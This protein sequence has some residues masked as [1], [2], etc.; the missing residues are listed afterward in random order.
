MSGVEGCE[1]LEKLMNNKKRLNDLTE[2]KTD[3]I[4]SDGLIISSWNWSAVLTNNPDSDRRLN[5][6]VVLAG[7][8]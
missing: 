7:S 1:G 5:I 8:S 4:V 6:V 3:G 2:I